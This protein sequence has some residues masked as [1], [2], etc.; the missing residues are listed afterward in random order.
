MA[1][2]PKLVPGETFPITGSASAPPASTGNLTAGETFPISGEEART[3]PPASKTPVEASSRIDSMPDPALGISVPVAGKSEPSK[4]WGS[5]SDFNQ[6]AGKF[7]TNIFTGAGFSKLGEWLTAPDET[8]TIKF[9]PGK[10]KALKA[11]QDASSRKSVQDAVADKPGTFGPGIDPVKT[12]SAALRLAE[13]A[14]MLHQ[15]LDEHG[16]HMNTSEEL[17]NL[18]FDWV[19]DDK[20]N[21]TLQQVN[22][23]SYSP[24]FI[25]NRLTTIT[26]NA[27]S[28]A[29][30][31]A[32]E[33]REATKSGEDVE[34]KADPTGS[35][36]DGTPAIKRT[37]EEKDVA[38]KKVETLTGKL[39]A[40][41]TSYGEVNGL[42]SSIVNAPTYIG[43]L[44][45]ANKVSKF[46]RDVPEK[47]PLDWHG[48]KA[49]ADETTQF[50]KG[51]SQDPNLIKN[52]T[53][54]GLEYTY[55]SDQ[56]QAYAAKE[57]LKHPGAGFLWLGKALPQSVVD[58]WTLN[59]LAPNIASLKE[60][61]KQDK[62]LLGQM[63]VAIDKTKKDAQKKGYTV[64]VIEDV[65]GK[66]GMSDAVGSL[67][68]TI[69]AKE[70][71]LAA[72]M[73]PV[74]TGLNQLVKYRAAQGYFD[75]LYEKNGN[76]FGLKNSIIFGGAL[77]LQSLVDIGST[78]KYH[79]A[80]GDPTPGETFKQYQAKVLDE[81]GNVVAGRLETMLPREAHVIEGR[82]IMVPFTS[83]DTHLFQHY[84]KDEKVP[85]NWDVLALT[86]TKT[87]AELA[88]LMATGAGAEAIG[89]RIA[90]GALAEDLALGS[91]LAMGG[92]EGGS[93]YVAGNLALKGLTQ[94]GVKTLGYAVP[95]TLIF[96]PDHV[97]EEM[98][99]KSLSVDNA[100]NLG[101]MRGLVE[102]YA[103]SINPTAMAGVTA[104]FMTGE[105]KNVAE[106]AAYKELTRKSLTKLLGNSI[107]DK[108]YQLLMNAK[109]IPLGMTETAVNLQVQMHLGLLGNSLLSKSVQSDKEDYYSPQ[110]EYTK[111][112]IVNTAINA[113]ATAPAFSLMHV[114]GTMAHDPARMA[115]DA[116]M[117]R[118]AHSP[119]YYTYRV[120]EEFEAGNIDEK[121]AKRQVDII[122]QISGIFKGI[123]PD[124]E[125]IKTNPNLSAVEKHKAKFDLFTNRLRE[126]EIVNRYEKV[127]EDKMNEVRSKIRRI[128]EE[129]PDINKKADDAVR[130][131]INTENAKPEGERLPRDQWPSEEK[132]RSDFKK[133]I[134]KENLSTEDLKV[135]EFIDEEVKLADQLLASGEKYKRIIEETEKVDKMTPEEKLVW[136]SQ[137]FW[138]HNP[139][140]MRDLEHASVDELDKRRDIL[141]GVELETTN[142]HIKKSVEEAQRIIEI[143]MADAKFRDSSKPEYANEQINDLL[144]KLDT[145][146]TEA[147]VAYDKTL[148]GTKDVVSDPVEREAFKRKY[149]LDRLSPREQFLFRQL[150]GDGTRRG[151]EEPPSWE[152]PAGDLPPGP[153]DTTPPEDKGPEPTYP[154]PKPAET[155]VTTGIEK[156]DAINETL[157]V[158]EPP[159]KVPAA[160]T[161]LPVIQARA[162][163]KTEDYIRLQSNPTEIDRT[164]NTTL[165]SFFKL[166]G[167]EGMNNEDGIVTS[168]DPSNPN[169]TLLMSPTVTIAYVGREASEDATGKWVSADNSLYYPYQLLHSV[170]HFQVGTSLTLKVYP[171]SKS[172]FATEAKERF[173][174]SSIYLVDAMGIPQAEIDKILADD[175]FWR[176]TSWSTGNE[177]EPE[178]FNH[179]LDYLRDD[180]VVPIVYLTNGDVIYNMRNEF[181]SMVE[182]HKKLIEL[183]DAGHT[184]K[185]T[186]AGSSIGQLSKNKDNKQ[187]PI[188]EAY[189]NPDALASIE[190][191]TDPEALRY[192]K[193]RPFNWKDMRPGM[194]VIVLPTSVPK[195]MAAI[196]LS[197]VKV[198]EEEADSIINAIKFFVESE[199][200]R[201]AGDKA[202]IAELEGILSDFAKESD[203]PN[204]YLLNSFVGVRHYMKNLVWCSEYTS[205]FKAPGPERAELK[206]VPFIDIDLKAR[207]IT[208]SWSR[209]NLDKISEDHVISEAGEDGFETLKSFGIFRQLLFTG[210]GVPNPGNEQFLKNFKSFLMTRPK[211]FQTEK[212][213]NIKGK[214]SIPLLGKST[215]SF[216][217]V[218]PKKAITSGSSY[219][220][221]FK[222]NLTTNNLEHVIQLP[223][224]SKEHVYFEQPNK[225]ISLDVA[226]DKPVDTD[227][228]DDLDK[229]MDF[230][231]QLK[232]AKTYSEAKEILK[233]APSHEGI[234]SSVD[235]VM[236]GLEKT[237]TY[238][239]K[240]DEFE[241]SVKVP[242]N[243]LSHTRA[244]SNKSPA[245][246]TTKK[247]EEEHTYLRKLVAAYPGYSLERDRT[248]TR[249]VKYDLIGPK[250]TKVTRKSYHAKPLDV[251]DGKIEAFGQQVGV[252]DA[253]PFME[254]LAYDRMTAYPDWDMS[255]K[256]LAQAVKY[257]N[258]GKLDKP[259][260]QQMLSKI[261]EWKSEGGVR[262]RNSPEKDFL[263]FDEFFGVAKEFADIDA[264]V[265]AMTDEEAENTAEFASFEALT[266]EEKQQIYDRIIEEAQ[267]E[268][269]SEAD[270]EDRSLEET[271][272]EKSGEITLES[273]KE[274]VSSPSVKDLEDS[275]FDSRD[276]KPRGADPRFPESLRTEINFSSERKAVTEFYASLTPEEQTKVG[277]LSDLLEELY[278]WSDEDIIKEIHCR[279]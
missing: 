68:E 273:Q 116:A 263:T 14:P 19:T 111:E 5:I 150:E 131:W 217:L 269:D 65:I 31:F 186:I 6:S 4:L 133:N 115:R 109:Y 176:Q 222:K 74:N 174:M 191:V 51:L 16:I 136:E 194:P 82:K 61:I 127:A 160:V 46:L 143:R 15:T 17:A 102:G 241:E 258:A 28:R 226:T 187:V 79:A 255:N 204:K 232:A 266:E 130:D 155:V 43:N 279:K 67:G 93:Q 169:N 227:E 104:R 201:V 190:I 156:V 181:Y 171:L 107:S 161:T 138:Q 18:G 49:A 252:E 34:A 2:N 84:L 251:V 63:G 163:E 202:R 262:M 60:S 244:F 271:E 152:P 8:E 56:Y 30:F 182:K 124:L 153:G 37:A 195:K 188:L 45:E 260:A 270:E 9:V 42:Y 205:K 213:E 113:L 26:Q 33:I 29:L 211:D 135:S 3:L 76:N 196:E 278:D 159:G 206:N 267:L 108:T 224:G 249:K 72:L 12:V 103:F 172:P 96:G 142:P 192:K 118:V 253:K 73:V 167:M 21:K 62:K 98:E 275:L 44:D 219:E 75:A 236:R 179:T 40:L 57:A 144:E 83:K 80:P 35:G 39:K 189:K 277:N 212:V 147:G 264:E 166:T 86:S 48:L 27:N 117:F 162:A 99:N 122:N 151:P 199:R 59:G 246:Q 23:P 71:T 220:D 209:I 81:D 261:A 168:P 94:L 126:S 66:S 243:L 121:E 134:Y 41:N 7:L 88:P 165:T 105:I 154:A 200:A 91:A 89:A 178:I 47:S 146:N 110:H 128:H 101:M 272:G 140:L 145:L 64:D 100:V 223:D 92:V 148:E 228:K 58:N 53:N 20:G 78:I 164:N 254:N 268:R 185:S 52:M 157:P 203:D 119:E 141:R 250:G 180:R 87:V 114:A 242:N 173:K 214:F 257:L 77:G 274:D 235:A 95:A 32:K 97:R 207:T 230:Y 70:E 229:I 221:Y 36:F 183:S 208:Y 248:E 129:D 177:H 239:E 54:A 259:A 50:F 25:K 13:T 137:K 215:T 112:N 55:T 123:E 170:K 22:P 237:K 216:H 90:T 1:D 265:D 184:I 158:D 256:Q 233:T 139:D 106:D 234:K 85:V 175:N 132:I 120:N 38:S 245:K 193:I 197:R 247:G 218:T 210:A 125:S 238:E 276:F 11:Q 225:L 10:D 198:S 24:Q 240:R 231:K 149:T 69:K